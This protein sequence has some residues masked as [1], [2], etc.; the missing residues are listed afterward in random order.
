MRLG[1]F[2]A[3]LDEM[4]SNARVEVGPLAFQRVQDVPRQATVAR[5][6]LNEVEWG[7]GLGAWGLRIATQVVEAL[8]DLHGEQ[9]AEQQS[10]VDAREEVASA[11]GAPTG[12]GVVA[13]FRVVQREV[14][15]SGGGE[16]TAAVNLFADEPK[17]R[18]TPH[19]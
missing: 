7:M 8:G 13:E 18:A 3:A 16:G 19:C 17:E 14:D 12:A 5:S 11:A 2:G 6:C 4:H 9:L 15:E 10:D 1:S